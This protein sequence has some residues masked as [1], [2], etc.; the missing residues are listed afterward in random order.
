MSEQERCPK[1]GA[2]KDFGGGFA[3]GG[4]GPYEFCVD[5]E[6][7]WWAKELLDE[8]EEHLAFI[9]SETAVGAS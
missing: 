6:C 9:S 7:G 3:F 5:E 1:C 8:N 4:Y 2:D